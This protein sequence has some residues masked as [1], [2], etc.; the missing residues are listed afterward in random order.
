VSEYA[1][2]SPEW[3]A[4]ARELRDEYAKDAPE[5]AQSVRANLMITDA[6]FSTGEI[7]GHIDT[8]AGGIAIDEGHI[9]DPELTVKTDYDTARALFVDRDP[10]KAMEAFMLGRILV[11]GDVSKVLAFASAPP[12]ADPEQLAMANEIARRLSDIT[13]S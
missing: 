6:P 11:T 8:S 5:P 13:A 1:F 9:D 12:P 4:A 2:L 3:I 7:N 10:A